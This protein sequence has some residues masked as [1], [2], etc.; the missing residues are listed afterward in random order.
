M[1]S[2]RPIQSWWSQPR[3]AA[4]HRL[5][6]RIVAAISG[7]H[8]PCV[9]EEF[10]CLGVTA[11]RTVRYV[12]EGHRPPLSR[13][14]SHHSRRRN[15]VFLDASPV[16]PAADPD[17]IHVKRAWWGGGIIPKRR[18]EKTRL[19]QIACRPGNDGNTFRHPNLIGPEHLG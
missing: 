12:V 15:D 19:D 6:S 16:Q 18:I 7:E 8:I 3:E 9:P 13:N 14:S 11:H 5:T 10:D 1:R 17:I 2:L 4:R